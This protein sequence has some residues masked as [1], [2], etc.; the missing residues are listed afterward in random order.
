M[1]RRPTAL[2]LAFLAIPWVA[3]GQFHAL[4]KGVDINNAVNVSQFVLIDWTNSGKSNVVA[5]DSL[6]RRLILSTTTSGSV[7][8]AELAK[9]LEDDLPDGCKL[10]VADIDSHKG[11]DLIPHFWKSGA[12]MDIRPTALTDFHWI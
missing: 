4:S 2:L 6:K 9:V 5:I 8:G 3:E 11:N 10:L 1:V 12:G 7:Q